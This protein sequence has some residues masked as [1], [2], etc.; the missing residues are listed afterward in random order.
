MQS[1]NSRTG[2]RLIRNC[3]TNRS[4]VSSNILTSV[5]S[6]DILSIAIPC[7]TISQTESPRVYRT[8][9]QRSYTLGP[10]II[11]STLGQ[12]SPQ[13]LLRNTYSILEAHLARIRSTCTTS[14]QH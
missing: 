10:R 3:L 6:T 5:K 12:P 11:H 13:P 8:L 7:I 1:R 9:Y 14:T 2:S 4:N